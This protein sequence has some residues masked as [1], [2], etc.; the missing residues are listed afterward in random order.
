MTE[1]PRLLFVS[2][3]FLFP[4]DAGGKI[5]TANILRQMKGGAFDIDLLSPIPPDGGTEWA[6]QIAEISDNFTGWPSEKMGL[7]RQFKR[8]FSF[9][10]YL[11]IAVRSEA[12]GPARRAFHDALS[13][14]PDM[15]I[16]DYVH[17]L[18]MAPKDFQH[19]A[20]FFAHNV[21]T[22]IFERHAGLT[23][24]LP[25]AVWSIEAKKM[26]RFERAACQIVDG[27]IA[28]SERDANYFS[29][30]LGAT[31]VTSIPT[32]VDLDFY[33]W[34]EPEETDP[35]TIIF[36][37][38]LDW[39]A[40]QDGL[41]WFMDEVWSLVV[42][43]IPGA[44]FKIVG[45]NP[46]PWLVTGA[47]DRNFDWTFTGFVDDI[48]D[49]ARGSVFVIPL[50]AGGGTRIK[51]FEAMAL[52]MSV[53]ST[54]LGVEG[55]AIEDGTH[56]ANADDPSDFARAIVDLLTDFQKR[57]KISTSARRLCEENFS[58]GA[59]AAIFE[60]HCLDILHAPR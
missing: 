33:A 27:V 28:V 58:H 45:K 9:F 54:T 19:K 13:R 30:K 41:K 2:P 55:L 43:A 37:G 12:R 22:E 38:S 52:G 57:K 11:P 17:S 1:K 4:M 31:G 24:G 44:S 15:V 40:N 29:E 18:G 34:R 21:E 3:Q 59:V 5:R 6:S 16:F 26:H 47:K 39:R 46:P 8:L 20:L 23:K 32:G 53:V 42:A 60:K 36:T 48:R 35:P 14:A 50:R 25:R 51:A 7:V 56:Y 49:H 10:S